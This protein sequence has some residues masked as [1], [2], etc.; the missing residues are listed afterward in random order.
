MSHSLNV[1]FRRMLAAVG[2]ALGDVE[3]P[4]SDDDMQASNA[5]MELL[6]CWDSRTEEF[7]HVAQVI[8]SSAL[9]DMVG[10]V[11]KCVTDGMLQAWRELKEGMPDD[12]VC[13]RHNFL[14]AL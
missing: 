13:L 10:E 6:D 8:I 14:D 3:N 5:A 4:I 1:L 7:L 9:A 12:V 11:D 2:K